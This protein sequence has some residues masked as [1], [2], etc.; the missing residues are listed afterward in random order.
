MTKI[1]TK[2]GYIIYDI[3][4]HGE[5][6]E[7][8]NMFVKENFRRKGFGSKLVRR[9]AKIAQSRGVSCIYLFTRNS[10]KGAQ[11]FYGANGFKHICS[12][13]NFYKQEA[14]ELYLK[15]I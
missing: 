3:P 8:T 15:K 5:N 1:D 11:R 4:L 13:P 12:I 6:L 9:V 10:N 14:G 2:E 7:I